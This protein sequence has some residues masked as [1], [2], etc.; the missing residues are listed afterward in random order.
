VNLALEYD[1]LQSEP[2]MIRLCSARSDST[3]FTLQVTPESANEDVQSVEAF[4][5]GL[6]AE[7]ID[8][9]PEFDELLTLA[10]G[11]TR[12]AH[13]SFA[14]P[15]EVADPDII[16]VR[17][18]LEI[19]PREEGLFG[20]SPSDRNDNDINGLYLDENGL[21]VQIRA[22]DDS[23][24]GSVGIEEG[25][26]LENVLALFELN[27]LPGDSTTGALAPT[28]L[29]EP[30]HLP[31]TRWVQDWANGEDENHGVTLRL[32]GEEERL[33]QLQWHLPEDSPELAPRLEIL[34]L[35]RPDFE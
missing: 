11:V 17:A 16:I 5:D 31:L 4:D 26:L 27:P 20:M 3:A 23:L 24:P 6:A 28:M 25:T 30:F 12:D 15:D 18:V 1:E 13:L 9:G 19:W 22:V 14:L 32:S 7:K 33:R 8:D 35:R 21:T 10:T 34:Y 29:R 2:G